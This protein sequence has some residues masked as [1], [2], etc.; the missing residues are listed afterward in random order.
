LKLDWVLAS[1][2]SKPTRRRNKAR[3]LG[4]AKSDLGWVSGPVL[5]LDPGLD[6]VSD[7]DLALLSIPLEPSSTLALLLEHSLMPL[8]VSDAGLESLGSWA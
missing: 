2:L 8:L 5:G 1:V 7:L 4:L 6:L 3:V